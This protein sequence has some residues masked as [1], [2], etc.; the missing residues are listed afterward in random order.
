VRPIRYVR[1]IL[2][3]CR[4]PKNAHLSR[5][6]RDYP[7]RSP[8]HGRAKSCFLFVATAPLILPRVK[9][10]AGLLRRTSVGNGFKPFPTKDFACLRVA[11]SPEAGVFLSSLQ[12]RLFH[13]TSKELITRDPF[14]FAQT[15]LFRS[16]PEHSVS[17]GYRGRILQI[18]LPLEFL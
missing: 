13:Y 9:H 3:S 16:L 7:A 14:S 15:L 8:S 11:A 17:S 6:S 4:Q 12:N 1:P 2:Y 5:A 10:G 18:S